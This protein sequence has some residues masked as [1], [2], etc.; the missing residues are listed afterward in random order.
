M[1]E[2]RK[3]FKPDRPVF[4]VQLHRDNLCAL[5][6]Q[7]WVSCSNP[8]LNPLWL[9]SLCLWVFEHTEGALEQFQHQPPS[10]PLPNLRKKKWLQVP[11]PSVS[12]NENCLSSAAPGDCTCVVRG[13]IERASQSTLW[14]SEEC[15]PACTWSRWIEICEG[16]AQATCSPRQKQ[17][18]RPNVIRLAASQHRL[19]RLPKH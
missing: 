8:S 6:A 13:Q 19:P 14:R 11:R 2:F 15:T 10:C 3:T 17:K 12:R 9:L 16:G 18:Y 1:K 4:K 5:A 7:P